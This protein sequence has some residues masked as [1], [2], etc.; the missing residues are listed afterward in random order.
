MTTHAIDRP[1]RGAAAAGPPLLGT[2]GIL[3]S[4]MLLAQGALAA[5]GWA[6]AGSV[7]GALGLVYLGGWGASL[8]GMRRLGVIGATGG[9][10]AAYGVQ[11][12]LLAAAALFSVQE[13]V[14]GGPDRVPFP[15]LDLAWPLGHTFMLVTG[16]AVLRAGAWRGWRRYAPLLCGLKIPLLVALVAAGMAAPVESGGR[17]AAGWTQ[18]AY[19]AAAFAALGYAVR[20]GRRPAAAGAGR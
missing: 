12:A 16:A 19:A 9:G 6:G 20:T 11:L 10:R 13:T 15:L 14:Y 1:A 7:G 8:V 5:S 18:V 4:P 3:A 17:G 2:L